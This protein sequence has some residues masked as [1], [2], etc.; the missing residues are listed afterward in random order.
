MN[1]IGQMMKAWKDELTSHSA[2]NQQ[3]F[4]GVSGQIT[5]MAARISAM[6]TGVTGINNLMTSISGRFDAI[7]K[8]I[9]IL[10]K[11]LESSATLENAPTMVGMKTR[12]EQ[13]ESTLGSSATLE[14]A[15]VIISMNDEVIA[16]K[17]ITSDMV[18]EVQKLGTSVKAEVTTMDLKVNDIDSIWVSS[19]GLCPSRAGDSGGSQIEKLTQRAILFSEQV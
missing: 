5:Q 13:V 4:D 17:A 9:D 2:D 11:F 10:D 19:D 7:D 15:S 12:I 6:E 14:N 8:N 18:T 16:L 3:Q 1:H